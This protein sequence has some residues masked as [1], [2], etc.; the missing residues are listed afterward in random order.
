MPPVTSSTTSLAQDLRGELKAICEGS[1]Y[2]R[3]TGT[4]NAFK[5]GTASLGVDHLVDNV[6]SVAEQV[7]S[8][9]TPNPNPSP[10]LTLTLTR[11]L[12]LSRW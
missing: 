3:S 10:S 6:M 5:V 2:R 11:T 7:V 4:S 8:K 12:T 9:P 1:F